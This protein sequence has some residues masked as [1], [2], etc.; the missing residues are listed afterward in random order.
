MEEELYDEN[1]SMKEKRGKTLPVLVVLSFIYIA[2]S[3][4]SILIQMVN[5]PMSDE[6]IEQQEYEMLQAY[7]D[8]TPAF[9]KKVMEESI[10]MLEKTQESFW[11]MNGLSVV[12]FVVGFFAVYLMF[13][14]KKVGYYMYIAYSLIPLIMSFALFSGYTIALLGIAFGAAISILFIILYGVQLKRMS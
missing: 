13:K 5:G 10:E 2:F 14:L 12:T 1:L 3:F 4:G 9:A 11:L 6:E 8:E 7:N